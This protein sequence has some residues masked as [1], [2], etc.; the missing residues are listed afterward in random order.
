MRLSISIIYR[1]QLIIE[2]KHVSLLKAM[3][4]LHICGQ[5]I[6]NQYHLSIQFIEHSLHWPVANNIFNNYYLQLIDQHSNMNI[7]SIFMHSIMQMR[8]IN[9]DQLDVESIISIAA[10]ESDRIIHNY[11]ARI[12]YD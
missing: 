5:Y 4:I 11:H 8:I 1:A 7:E 10:I 9:D 6:C 12:N 2:K 3:I